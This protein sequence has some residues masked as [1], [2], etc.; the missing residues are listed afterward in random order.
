MT[1]LDD[2]SQQRRPLFFPVVIATVLLTII[3]MIGGYL[4]GEERNREPRAEVTPEPV[5]LVDGPLCPEQT[6]RAGAIQGASGEL[7]EVLRVRTVRKTVIWI[8]QDR[9]GQL[10]YH[11]NKGGTDADWIENK[12]ALFLGGVWQDSN[13]SY[14]AT[15]VD[16]NV[17]SVDET[18]LTIAYADGTSEEQKAVRE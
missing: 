13:G 9:T 17:F 7:V 8:C 11:A 5:T 3:G 12:T 18:G 1:P 14:V 10:F 16:G 15:A 4:L 6:Q 2:H